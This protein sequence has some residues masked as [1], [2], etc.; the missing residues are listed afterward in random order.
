MFLPAPIPQHN[1]SG[2]VIWNPNGF[3][4]AR[5]VSP[6]PQTREN[7]QLK[8]TQRKWEG[9]MDHK[10]NMRSSHES[11]P[12]RTPNRHWKT[13]VARNYQRHVRNHSGLRYCTDTIAQ[14]H[15][16]HTHSTEQFLRC[17]LNEHRH[18]RGH[19]QLNQ[20]LDCKKRKTSALDRS[21][22]DVRGFEGKRR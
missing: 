22:K 1:L 8:E 13:T 10:R 18:L 21:H 20:N 9:G 15:A 12:K 2:A 5:P 7:A 14:L 3:P 16:V 19:E 4:A 11:V 17:I 6:W